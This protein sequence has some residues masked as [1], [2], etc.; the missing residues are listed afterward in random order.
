MFTLEIGIEDQ[1]SE[2][3]EVNSLKKA[4]QIA[5]DRVKRGLPVFI[6]DETTGAEVGVRIRGGR[7]EVIHIRHGTSTLMGPEMVSLFKVMRGVPVSEE[8]RSVA[9]A[10]A[11]DALQANRRQKGFVSQTSR[12]LKMFGVQATE[13]I[14]E[15]ESLERNIEKTGLV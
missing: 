14:P 5:A 15:L 11:V 13:V 2:I 8:E 12:G 7:T 6:I 1:E 3:L 4:L 9:T 10:G